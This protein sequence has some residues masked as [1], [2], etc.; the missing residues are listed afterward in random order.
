MTRLALVLFTAAAT[1][2]SADWQAG[3]AA[4]SITPTE[5]IWLAGYASRT[6][7]HE[8]VRQ[9]IYAKAL[10]LRESSS[11]PAAVVITLDLVSIRRAQAEPIAAEIQ[12]RHGIPRDRILFN[13]SHTHS[14][15]ILGDASSYVYHFG[16][17]P[18]KY[19]A[20][21]ARY[22]EFARARIL[23]AVDQALARM[24]PA[25]LS[26][27]QSFAGFAVNR[28]RVTNRNWP[29][30]V[31]HDVPVLAVRN[32]AGAVRAILF[33]Y[34]CHN[35]VMGDDTVHGD[36]AGYAQ[37]ALEQRH[38][39]AVALFVQG[40]GADQNPL[41]RRKVEHLER[42]GATLADAVE[43]VLAAKPR[44]VAGP[45]KSAMEFPVLNFQPPPARAELEK[46]AASA[47]DLERRHAQRLLAAGKITDTVLYPVQ[48][49]SFGSFRLLA[50][51][52][53]LVA[54]YSV[55]FKNTYGH[56]ALWVAG[57]SNDVF[58]YIPSLRVLR[59]GGYEG[60]GAYQFSGFP[61][62][63]AADVEDRIVSAVDRV[64]EKVK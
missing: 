53:E 6:K 26:F 9:N 40:A 2:L 56:D 21:I 30:P 8:G 61:G 12:K 24:E 20:P 36:Y 25:T 44:A 32:A 46:Q 13:A 55:R 1:A 27:G 15:P 23:E 14:A 33:G 52:G 7:P 28:R 37:A 62:P 58:G 47:N 17:K 4:V 5:P 18:E 11:G 57:Y 38:P 34:A 60:G 48:A 64:M 35:T 42:Y 19:L 16:D 31:D 10:A 43:E 29:G 3:A 45:L 59:E 22:G 51:A 54:D 39:G 49:W 50:L 63:L 41:P